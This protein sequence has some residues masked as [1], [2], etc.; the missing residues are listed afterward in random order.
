MTTGRSDGQ[1]EGQ[2]D[3]YDCIE[4]AQHDGLGQT[5]TTEGDSLNVETQR[6][7][8]TAAEVVARKLKE[9]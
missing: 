9:S 8:M 4:I 1:L 7:P 6:K 3:V 5:E 2:L